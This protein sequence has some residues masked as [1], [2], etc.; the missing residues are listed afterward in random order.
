MYRELRNAFECGPSR[1]AGRDAI[2]T[3]DTSIGR[4]L[5]RF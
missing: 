2:I 1:G 4:T 5:G 3:V